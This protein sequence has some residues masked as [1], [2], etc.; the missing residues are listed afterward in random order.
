MSESVSSRT[1]IEGGRRVTKTVRV[2]RYP[3]G[4]EERTEETHEGDGVHGGGIL[5]AG[6]GF[7]GFGFGGLGMLAHD[8]FG[9]SARGRSQATQRWIADSTA[10]RGSA[11][12]PAGEGSGRRGVEDGSSTPRSTKSTRSTRSRGSRK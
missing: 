12:P 8:P 5:E 3:D 10:G 6:F 7:D 2:R 1:V 9:E 4:R 11:R